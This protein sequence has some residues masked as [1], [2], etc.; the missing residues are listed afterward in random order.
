MNRPT[1]V[2]DLLSRRLDKVFPVGHFGGVLDVVDFDIGVFFL[3]V[4]SVVPVLVDEH[5]SAVWV[6]GFPEEGFVGE[7]EDE[8]VARGGGRA[9]A[10][11]VGDG[12]DV[13]VGHPVGGVGVGSVVEEGGD[14]GL[15]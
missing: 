12:F 1:L 6:Q 2:P 15:G 7:A 14:D 3:D 13:G 9:L 10:E 4:G 8:E 5:G 11:G